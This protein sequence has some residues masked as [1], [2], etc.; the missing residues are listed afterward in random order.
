MNSLF[1]NRVSRSLLAYSV[2]HVAFS[3]STAS[4]ASVQSGA[5]FLK[6]D[7]TARPAA[8]AGAYTGTTGDLDTMAYNPGGLAGLDHREAAFT[9]AEW[10][11]GSQYD[12]L[13]YGHP[14][15]LGTFGISVLRQGYGDLDGRDASRQTT[16]SF[17]AYDSA[18]TLAYGHSVGS[19]LGMGAALKVLER[20]I[21]S[22]RASSYAMDLGGVAGRQGQPF[23]L[24]VSIL[25][26]GP[27]MRFIDQYDPLPLTLAA[28]VSYQQGR[29][30]RCLVDLK[31]E[32][33]DQRTTAMTGVEYSPLEAIALRGGYQLPLAGTG[34][35]AGD[36]M[37]FRGGIGLQVSRF[38]MDYALA[39]FGDLGLT[40]RF[41]LAMSFG[42][43]SNERGVLKSARAEA[44]L[45]SQKDL[46]T[47]VSNP[48]SF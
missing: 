29:T 13:A 42:P 8:L 34:D 10:L 17:N 47:L 1:L 46:Q 35:K 32:P 41:T 28:G 39:P 20:K 43:K 15:R 26:I 21:G 37:N 23:R 45:E 5:A 44:S 22:D 9:H 30:W 25:N 36:L 40:H 4:A 12:Y 14:T 7:P 31:H 3:L 27:G 19:G 2:L 48:F 24:G 16:G 38:R 11:V 6:I 33:N 18:F